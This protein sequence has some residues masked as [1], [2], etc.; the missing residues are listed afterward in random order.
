VIHKVPA[1]R[2]DGMGP[3][4]LLMLHP[5]QP[6]VS[7]NESAVTEVTEGPVGAVC[8]HD[9]GPAAA[10]RL[11]RYALRHLDHINWFD[12]VQPPHGPVNR[13]SPLEHAHAER[14]GAKT[15][16]GPAKVIVRTTPRG[17][18]NGDM[19]WERRFPAFPGNGVHDRHSVAATLKPGKERLN[20]GLRPPK[21]GND[22]D[23]VH[24]IPA[25][26][27]IMLAGRSESGKTQL[28]RVSRTTAAP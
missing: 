12:S 22:I 20:I 16:N 19:H 13:P 3:L 25:A 14:P 9:H 23:N 24:R 4:E 21:R 15:A 18:G 28:Y 1:N 10:Q 27:S 8:P 7:R 11:H 5:N 17:V 2:A 6:V 26:D